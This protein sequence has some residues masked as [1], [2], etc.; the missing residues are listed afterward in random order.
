MITSYCCTSMASRLDNPRNVEK[1]SIGMHF[2]G[3]RNSDGELQE[4]VETMAVRQ[5]TR[6]C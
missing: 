3:C 5:D 1:P 6:F 2:H 4:I